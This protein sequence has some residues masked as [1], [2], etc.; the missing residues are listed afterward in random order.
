MKLRR[1]RFL[2][3]RRAVTLIELMVALALS[4]IVVAGVYSLFVTQQRSYSL[5]DQISAIQQDARAALTIVAREIRMAGFLC[6]NDNVTIDGTTYYAP[7]NPENHSDGPDA[8]TLVYALKE[9]ANVTNINGNQVTLDNDVAD[10][11]DTSNKQFLAFEALNKIYRVTSVN[12]NVVTLNE[13]PPSY[14]DD[15]GA[16]V[17]AVRAV[18]YYVDDYILRRDDHVNPAPQPVIGGEDYPIVEDL[19]F[20]YLLQGG[21]PDDPND[22]YDDVVG[23][24]RTKIKAVRISLLTRTP[25]EDPDDRNYRRPALEDHPG[26]D[27]ADGY[28][29]RLY[30][31]VVKLRNIGQ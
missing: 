13:S 24:D 29:R 25:K 6:G 9:V 2:F 31:T 8:I 10:E 19:Q 16:Q 21:D 26:S 30:T 3:D 12:G 4:A 7:L 15:F 22:W 11:F 23:E 20:R 5:Q 28:R 18:T 1:V 27:V 17:F 14:L